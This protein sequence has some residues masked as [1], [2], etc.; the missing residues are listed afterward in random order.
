MSTA[1]PRKNA[2]RRLAPQGPLLSAATNYVI[3]VWVGFEFPIP[4]VPGQ[5]IPFWWHFWSNNRALDLGTGYRAR[6]LLGT[7]ELFRTHG[8]TDDFLPYVPSWTPVDSGS[9]E[10]LINPPAYFSTLGAALYV[11]GERELLLE[12]V[13]NGKD[14]GP[15]T[16]TAPLT[17]AEEAVDARWWRWPPQYE[18]PG[19]LGA[20]LHWKQPYNVRGTFINRSRHS[21]MH[22]DAT[23][24]EVE[25]TNPAFPRQYPAT[26]LDRQLDPDQ[27]STVDLLLSHEIV[28]DWRWLIPG[29]WYPKG[30]YEKTFE[31]RA[32]F[33]LQDAFGNKYTPRTSGPMKAHVN[34]TSDKVDLAA[35]AHG[36]QLAT[37]VLAAAS[38][39]LWFLGV[40]ATATGV[41]AAIMGGLALDPP[42]PDP[43]FL[44][45]VQPVRFPL[46]RSLYK[47]KRLQSFRRWVEAMTAVAGDMT[48]L[49]A[50][51]ARLLGAHRAGSRR[52]LALQGEAYLGV[53]Q[54]MVERAAA[55]PVL[56]EE[57]GKALEDT[58]V[59][60]ARGLKRSL[61]AARWKTALSKVAAQLGKEGLRGEALKS[62]LESYRLERLRPLLAKGIRPVLRLGSLPV[63][64]A[65]KEVEKG[66]ASV[67][68]RTGL[69]TRR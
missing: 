56:T 64:A 5:P 40:A 8:L 62:A 26:D 2:R 49:I 30:P 33:V 25:G 1:P 44:E 66:A 53:L 61:T 27:E 35:A 15:Y 51:H 48:T 22:V 69:V 43:R 6:V 16:A 24:L 4:V 14:A 39:V 21:R 28:Q 67:L 46:P 47:E 12:I 55:L 59:L 41:A 58:G 9:Q 7:D 50:I 17:V 45:P 31:Y 68:L 23:L 38:Y 19:L 20:R 18:V 52:G 65:A 3:D 29:V 32:E 57:A 54:A 13:T 42:E 37:I 11:F 63:I 10:R 34:V 60:S 36:L